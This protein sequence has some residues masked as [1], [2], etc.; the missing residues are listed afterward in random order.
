MK[1]CT[2]PFLALALMLVTACSAPEGRT[3]AEQRAYAIMVRN[4]ALAELYERKPEAKAKLESA[5]GYLFMSGFSL[6][7]GIGTF[8]NAYGIVHNN[9]ANTQT[10]IRLTRFGLGPGIAV[11]GY[12]LVV[13]LNSDEAVAAVESGRWVGGGLAE[14]SFHFGDF[15]GSACAEGLG[16]GDAVESFVWTHTGVALELAAGFG[17][18]YPEDELNVQ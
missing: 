15:G 3:A 2:L 14:A 8:A 1:R 12:Y 10:H 4:E 7:P 9:R 11:K 17:K 18:V 6:H 13:I 5:P 16:G